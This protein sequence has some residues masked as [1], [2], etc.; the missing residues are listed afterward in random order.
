VKFATKWQLGRR[1]LERACAAGIPARWVTG[2][3][4]YG[5]DWRLRSWLD[6]RRQA[7]VLAVSEQYRI[8]TGEQRQWAKQV[9]AELPQES[10]QVASCGAGSKGERLYEWVRL[11]M[12]R[13]ED[14]WHRWLLNQNA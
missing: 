8:F 5:N 14:G 12:R 7:Y 3:T 11:E 13:G 4:V 6:E 10:W 2:D 1:M 9:I